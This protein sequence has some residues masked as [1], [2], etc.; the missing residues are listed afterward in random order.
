MAGSSEQTSRRLLQFEEKA[1]PNWFA[2]VDPVLC[3]LLGSVDLGSAP[4]LLVA[5][6]RT[7]HIVEQVIEILPEKARLMVVDSS[8]EMLDLARR[9]L[10]ASK[11]SI[12]Y[13]SQ[14]STKL[15][16]ADE[17]FHAVVSSAGLV[18]RGDLGLAGTEMLRVLRP[19]GHLAVAIPLWPT[20]SNVPDLLAESVIRLEMRDIEP[21]LQNFVQAVL[22]E[23]NLEEAFAE[24]GLRVLDYETVELELEFESPEDFFFSPLVEGPFLP[25]WL[26]ICGDPAQR[27]PLL[28]DMIR[29]MAKYFQDLPLTTTAKLG[30]VL[31]ARHND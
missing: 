15:S 25:R 28:L 6:C 21:S 9:R 7:G 24:L 2:H 13:S 18:T 30:C 22:R 26:A 3:R 4:T 31:C 14:P 19:E 20:F 29:A 17:V 5:D 11:R 23:D 16:Y 12:F 1:V 27:Q 10:S 8:S